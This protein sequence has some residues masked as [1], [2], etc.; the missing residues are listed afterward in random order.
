MDILEEQKLLQQANTARTNIIA[1][2]FEYIKKAKEYVESMDIPSII[3]SIKVEV[4]SHSYSRDTYTASWSKFIT[5][6]DFYT[7]DFYLEKLFPQKVEDELY[8]ST[9]IHYRDD[10]YI[11]E[12]YPDKSKWKEVAAEKTIELKKQA[13]EAYENRYNKFE[14]ICYIAKYYIC[15]YSKIDTNVYVKEFMEKNCAIWGKDNI[16]IFVKVLEKAPDRFIGLLMQDIMQ[17]SIEL[18][19]SNKKPPFIGAF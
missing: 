8:S 6:Y 3:D 16:E 9:D 12:K 15:R 17:A 4:L 18:E 13:K 5:F 11:N 2:C 10:L 14:H 19:K 1:E 7:F